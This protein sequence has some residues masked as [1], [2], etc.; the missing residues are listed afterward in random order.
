MQTKYENSRD[1]DMYVITAKNSHGFPE[2]YIKGFGWVSF[3]PTMTP[4][5]AQEED[6]ER[7]ATGMLS[8]TGIA[9]L[10]V[11]IVLLLFMLAYPA[12]SH[13]FFRIINNRKRP[14]EAVAGVIHRIC[15]LYKIPVSATSHETEETVRFI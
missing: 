13:K 10:G 7:Q 15:R 12:L 9:I 2:L 14:N 8:E 4:N 1:D 11:C 5:V 3:E 6:N